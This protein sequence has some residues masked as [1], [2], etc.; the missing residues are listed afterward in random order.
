MEKSEF[1]GLCFEDGVKYLSLSCLSTGTG[2]SWAGPLAYS[3]KLSDIIA[4]G[5]CEVH[6]AKKTI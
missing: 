4:L 6:P 3:E 2:Q 1:W 5:K